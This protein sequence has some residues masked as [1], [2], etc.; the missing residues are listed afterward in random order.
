MHL[1]GSLSRLELLLRQAVSWKDSDSL[2][3][4][5]LVTRLR[6]LVATA[7]IYRKKKLENIAWKKIV[8]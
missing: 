8:G 4:L 2:V 6:F 1:G 3:W 7:A 5:G